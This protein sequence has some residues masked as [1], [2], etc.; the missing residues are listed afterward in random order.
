MTTCKYEYND[1]YVKYK[2]DK[3][4]LDG[5]D[6]CI[7]HLELPDEFESEEFNKINEQKEMEIKK[8]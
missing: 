6:Y 2:C 7:L 8:R 1:E 5:Y 4:A 3:E